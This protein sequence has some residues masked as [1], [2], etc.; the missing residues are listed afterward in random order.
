MSILVALALATAQ[1]AAP[2][3]PAV[4]ARPI[5]PYSPFRRAGDLLFVSG[6]IAIDPATGKFDPTL[7]IE[8]QTRLVWKNIERLLRENGLTLDDVQRADV[9]LIDMQDFARMNAAYA[10]ALGT[11][12]PARTTVA[13]MALPLGARIEITVI[14]KVGSPSAGQH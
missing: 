3:L 9:Y 8:A 7:S 14:A 10:E 2:P 1:S 12:R 6:Q 11:A 13:V 5:G 4:A